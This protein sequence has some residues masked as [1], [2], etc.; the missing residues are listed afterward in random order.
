GLFFLLPR[1]ADDAFS[2]LIPHRLH[3]PGFSNQITL[4]EIGEIK[5]TS[6]PVMHIRVYKDLRSGLK[7]RGSTLT[8]FDGKRWFNPTRD[9]IPIRVTNGIADLGSLSDMPPAR[10][11]LNYQVSFDELDTDTLFFA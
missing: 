2:R 10:K 3:L 4:G 5:N 8:D 1:T 7:W 9:R 6:R 11:G